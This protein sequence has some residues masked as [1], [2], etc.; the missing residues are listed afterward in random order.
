MAFSISKKKGVK[1]EQA[2]KRVIKL[3]MVFWIAQIT[4]SALV[5]SMT[6]ATLD[7]NTGVFYTVW[8]LLGMTT[9]S[10]QAGIIALIGTIAVLGLVYEFV[11]V[12]F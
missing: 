9:G 4:I 12:S 8:Q 6:Q 7:D 5:R 3:V 11:D 1:P 2:I 10:S